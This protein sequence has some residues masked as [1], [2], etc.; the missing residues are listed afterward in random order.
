MINYHLTGDAL[1]HCVRVSGAKIMI[2]D[3]DDE[4]RARIE[5]TRS[6][7]EGELGVKIFIL[8]NKLKAEINALEP[9]RPP[10]SLRSGM[11]PDYPMALFYTR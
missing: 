6:R 10:D 5:E 1:V 9:T 2:V 4:V 8:D 7:L 11:K 3:S